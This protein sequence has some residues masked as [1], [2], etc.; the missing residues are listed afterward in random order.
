MAWYAQHKHTQTFVSKHKWI[1]G[2][3]TLSTVMSTLSGVT[4]TCTAIV[5]VPTC[6]Y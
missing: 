5:W 6:P 1:D 2:K 4:D 3:Q